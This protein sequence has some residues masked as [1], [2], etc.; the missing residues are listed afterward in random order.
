MAS[1]QP[2]RQRHGI[3]THLPETQQAEQASTVL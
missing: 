2:V 1:G 3:L